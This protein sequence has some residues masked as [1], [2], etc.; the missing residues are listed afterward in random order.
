MH[1]RTVT[2]PVS[3]ACA[4]LVSAVLL[5]LS[6]TVHGD[7]GEAGDSVEPI[8]VRGTSEIAA[9]IV[10]AWVADQDGVQRVVQE[11]AARGFWWTEATDSATTDGRR[12][13]TVREGPRARVGV[14]VRRHA[15][16]GAVDTAYPGGPAELSRFLDAELASWADDGH[17]FVALE[18][19]SAAEPETGL[20]MIDVRIEPGPRV[21]VARAVPVGNTITR[22]EVIAREYRRE[23]GLF[24]SPRASERWRSRLVRTGYF[25][26]VGAP[27]LT[28]RDSAQG[29]A[30]LFLEVEEG[31]PN[32]FEG[33]VG[34]QPGAGDEK[35]SF[36]G[37]IDLTLGNLWGAGRR[38][39]ARWER[40]EPA[41]TTLDLSYREPWIGGVPADL[42]ASISIEQREGYALE[43]FD[44]A[45]SA[46]LVPGLRLSGGI[47]R[48]RAR[49]DSIALLGGPR[50]SGWAFAAGADYDTRDDLLNPREGLWYRL[51]WRLS[52]RRNRVGDSDFVRFFGAD[53][54]PEDER[55]SRF[56]IDLDHYF[57]LLA[58]F[59]GALSWHGVDVA[60]GEGGVPSEAD[61]ARL[62]GAL[63]LRGYRQDQFSG[64]RA[65]WGNHELRYLVGTSSRLFVF[66][67]GG[68]VRSR[69]RADE[70]SIAT[71]HAWALG[72]GAGL[73]AS[74]AA[75]L[76]G[77]DFGW[78]RDDSF[79]QGKVHVRLETAF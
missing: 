12:V 38:L 27:A 13:V 66:V 43:Y 48:E 40:P 31:K 65:I 33:I 51:S 21:R 36:T 28:W 15:D 6:P 75:G 5:A 47:G 37:L 42:E 7:P 71:K 56:R 59:V 9:P 14:R 32:R 34:Y 76:L 23:P 63:T 77:I 60:G 1:L 2:S 69:T 73:R 11:Y 30:D 39:T 52:L 78:G 16:A 24:Y 25:D 19:V 61:R 8:E 79:G 67:D 64:D 35:S 53:V 55:M 26:W 45:F 49:S 17:P 10:R 57:R 50:H 4:T 68:Y 54:W 44:A 18:L 20:T 3:V 22:D 70:D 46:E 62:G 72:W 41:T 58:G 29:V 74:T